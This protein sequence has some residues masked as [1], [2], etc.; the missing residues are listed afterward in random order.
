MIPRPKVPRR[1]T[2]PLVG[3]D[4]DVLTVQPALWRIHRTRGAHVL[5]W[6]AFRTFGPLPAAR[7]DP[8]PEPRG[9]HPTYGISYTAA[10]LRTAIDEVFQA[11]RRVDTTSG[12]PYATSFT[13]IRPLRLLDLTGCW[14]VRNGAGQSLAIAPRPTCRAW[15][16]AIHQ[17]WDDIDG[18]WAPSTLTGAPIVALYLKAAP[19]IP[20]T[21]EF[22]RPLGT[23]MLWTAVARGA[24][25]IGYTIG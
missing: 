19:A 7:Y 25:D 9:E 11:T 24:A 4:D 21:P 13:P 20:A 17:Q 16:R 2:G 12:D 1:P 3:S 10:D 6:N 18:L 15:S 8:H 5:A 23:S 14:P 22:S